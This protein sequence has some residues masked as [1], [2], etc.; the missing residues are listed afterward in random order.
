MLGP[1]ACLFYSAGSWACAEYWI[2]FTS[3]LDIRPPYNSANMTDRR[4]F[5]TKWSLYGMPFPFLPLE[6]IQSHCLAYRLR[7]TNV[8]RAKYCIVSIPHNTA[9]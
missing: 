1:T 2:H 7:T 3:F 9:I 6:S 8:L 4:K 5:T